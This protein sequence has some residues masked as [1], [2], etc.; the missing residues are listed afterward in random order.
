MI[1][2]LSQVLSPF[3]VDRATNVASN[4]P[5]GATVKSSP[6]TIDYKNLLCGNNFTL[7]DE[8]MYHHT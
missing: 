1:V 6:S 8:N 4:T 5:G 7:L 2:I 3:D